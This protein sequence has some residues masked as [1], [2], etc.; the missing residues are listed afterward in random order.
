MKQARKKSFHGRLGDR[1]LVRKEMSK[2]PSQVPKATG[3]NG[4]GVWKGGWEREKT[5]K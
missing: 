3:T 4:R 1:Q 2:M 5:K